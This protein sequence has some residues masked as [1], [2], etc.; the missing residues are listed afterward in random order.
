M[1]DKV[2]FSSK[3]DL[4]ETP[5][6]LFNRYDAHYHFIL[7]AAANDTNHKCPRWLGPGGSAE[8]AL[9]VD[10]LPFLE[11]GN[12]WLNPPYS[13]GL[14]K[15]FLDKVWRSRMERNRRRKAVG[16]IVCLLPARTDTKIFHDIILPNG[17]IEFLRGRVKFVGGKSAAPFPSMSVVF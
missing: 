5:N 14:Q 6:D 9:L 7:D 1:V 8:D 10:W 15:S 12:I 2:H 13:R 17:Q 4:W 16:R 3:S 11:V